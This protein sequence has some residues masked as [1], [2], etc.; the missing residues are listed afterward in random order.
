MKIININEDV[1]SYFFKDE[2][3]KNEF[4]LANADKSGKFEYNGKNIQL[5]YFVKYSALATY[6]GNKLNNITFYMPNWKAEKVHKL[7]KAR[8]KNKNFD[9]YHVKGVRVVKIY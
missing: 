5:G 3:L 1:S 7:F 4:K 2:S 6:Q 9:L 8:L